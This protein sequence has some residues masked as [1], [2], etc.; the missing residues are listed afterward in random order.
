VGSALGSPVG[1]A[2]GGGAGSAVTDNR[3]GGCAT[4][5]GD[6]LRDE[7]PGRKINRNAITAAP[8]SAT[9]APAMSHRAT[10]F[11]L[12]NGMVAVRSEAVALAP[13]PGRGIMCGGVWCGGVGNACGVGIGYMGGIGVPGGWLGYGFGGGP[14]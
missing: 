10:L 3:G 14:G 2:L 1:D 13:C 5:T 4:S 12:R 8:I 6:A 11:G 7:L 9:T